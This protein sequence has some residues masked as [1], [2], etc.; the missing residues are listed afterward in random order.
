MN[1]DLGGRLVE[2]L[3]R[4]IL[5][6]A[7][8]LEQAVTTL[9][10]GGHLLIEDVPGV[11]KTMLG[12]ALARS[13]NLDFQRIQFTSDLLPADILGVSVFRPENGD[14]EFKPGPVFAHIILADELNR[15]PPRTQSCLLEALEDGRVTI[16]GQTYQLPAP[17][18]VLATQNP[19]E[20]AG[21]YPLPE[22]ELDRFTLCVS[23]GYPDRE[24]EQRILQD[25]R[26]ASPLE[27]LEPV[28]EAA[29]ILSVRESVEQVR[30]DASVLSYVLDVV[31]A[32]RREPRVRLGASPRAALALDRVIRAR[33]VVR[34]RDY[35]IPEDV[36]DMAVPVLAHRIVP[37]G[38]GGETGRDESARILAELLERIPV[39]A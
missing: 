24:A 25:R 30:V 3:G 34:G 9:F 1:G 6:K 23:I 8:V 10:A 14:F 21:T 5:G 29:E 36:K 39:P 12:R 2:N 32:T 26:T 11:G 16:D 35:C 13:L 18:F 19:M 31:E 27:S 28:A 7:E 37:A 4:V 22:S 17:F 20:F 33:A 38:V 15:T